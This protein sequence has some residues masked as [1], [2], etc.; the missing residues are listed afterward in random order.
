VKFDVLCVEPGPVVT[1]ACAEQMAAGVAKLTG[2]SVAVAVTGVGGPDPEEAK[3]AG[4]VWLAVWAEGSC[5][6]ELLSLDGS[7]PEILDA[8][9]ARALAALAETCEQ[10]RSSSSS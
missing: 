7:P 4:T 1:Q 9:I 2:A 10:L 5:R 6:A 3:P 8:T